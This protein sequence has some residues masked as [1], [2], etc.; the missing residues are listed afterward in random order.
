MTFRGKETTLTY[1][2]PGDDVSGQLDHGE[3]A[4]ADGLLEFVVADAHQ[5][6]DGDSFSRHFREVF[7]VPRSSSP[8]KRPMSNWF[9]RFG[10]LDGRQGELRG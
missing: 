9:P 1:L 5:F 2:G 10:S 7:R 3:V 8:T 6:L 4:L